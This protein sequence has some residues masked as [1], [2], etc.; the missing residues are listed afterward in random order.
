MSYL[1]TFSHPIFKVKYKAIILL[2][3]TSMFAHTQ[4]LN[5][6]G[7]LLLKTE[8]TLG[9][10]NKTVKLSVFGI[11]TLNYGDASLEAGFSL[12]SGQLFQRHTKQKKG[13]FY[14]YDVFVLG[15]TGDNSNLLAASLFANNQTLLFSNSPS[16]SFNGIGFGF[17]KEFLPDDLKIFNLRRGKVIMRFSDNNHSF[18]IVF[19]NDFRLYPLFNGQGTDYGQTGGIEFGFSKIRSRQSAYQIGVGLELF[20]AKADYSKTPL[21]PINS[22]DGRKNVWYTLNPYKDLFYTNLYAIGSYQSN[23]FQSSLK[24]GLNSQK[25][26]AFVQN[27]LHDNFGLNPRFPWQVDKKDTLI[28]EASA[29]AFNTWT[30]D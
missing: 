24:L 21:N 28:I 30:D 16:G 19:T 14:G 11:G 15:G 20:T 25:L 22:D 4:S 13:L 5:S 17:Q 27:K 23:H 18:K 6:N 10:Q 7:G 26:G 29:S 2:V 9:N 3:F 1:N 12:F 8:I